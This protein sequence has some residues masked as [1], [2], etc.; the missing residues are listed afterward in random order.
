MKIAYII[1]QFPKYSETFIL[2]ELLALESLGVEVDIY[3]LR[4]PQRSVIQPEARSLM[5]RVHYLAYIGP[6]V[7]MAQIHYLIRRPLKYMG[8]WFYVV[9]HSLGSWE[10]TWKSM[11][12]LPKIFAFARIIEK[13]RPG[14]IHGHT[15]TYG[16][17]GAMVVSMMTGIPFSFTAHGAG[18]M[19]RNPVFLFRKVKRSKFCITVSEYNRRYLSDLGPGIADKI[20]IVRCGIDVDRFKPDRLR[21]HPGKGVWRILTVARLDPVKGLEHL[22]EAYGVLKGRGRSFRASIVGNGPERASLSKAIAHLGLRERVTLESAVDQ[23]Q[24]LARLRSADLFVLS[25]ISE[26][27]PIVLMEAMACEVPVIASRITGIP[28]LIQDGVEGLLAAP[29]D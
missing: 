1:G 27:I 10:F 18:D 14:H 28:E 24:I 22:V 8:L 25:S 26:G 17:L 9:F 5:N 16:A 4:N 6:E 29:A 12:G 7:F 3:S 23:E 15:A 11:A 20:E 13:E 2:N 19:F 21:S